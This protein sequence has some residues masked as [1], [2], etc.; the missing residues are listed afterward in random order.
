MEMISSACYDT[1]KRCW[2][3]RR[4]QRLHCSTN[5]KR[6]L[7]II[8]LGGAATRR[9]WKLRTTAPKLQW[10]LLSPVRIL[11]NFHDAYVDMMI[12]LANNM[13]KLNGRGVFGRKKFAKDKQISMVSCGEEVDTRLVLEIYKRLVAARELRGF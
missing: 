6:K 3:R 7:K 12:R 11:V 2:R 10:K 9:I 13:G 5:S 1:L 8:R 4:Y